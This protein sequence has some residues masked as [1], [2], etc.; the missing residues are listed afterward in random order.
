MNYILVLLTGRA[1]IWSAIA[2]IYIVAQL[3]VKPWKTPHFI[4]YSKKLEMWIIYSK[5]MQPYLKTL[6]IF[7]CIYFKVYI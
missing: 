7:L 5:T 2:E 1:L 6:S 4:I 3:S